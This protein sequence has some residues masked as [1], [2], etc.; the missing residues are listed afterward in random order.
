MFKYYDIRGVWGR[1]ID[2]WKAEKLGAAFRQLVEGEVAIGRDVRLSSDVLASHLAEGLGGEVVDIGITT[3]PM[4]YFFAWR[5]GIHTLQVTAS[6]NPP[7]YNGVKPIDEGG[8]DWPPEKIRELEKAYRDAYPEGNP[9]KLF[10]RE[11]VDDYFEIF[12]SWE[13]PRV[14]LGADLSSGAGYL[15]L[16]LLEVLFD[17]KAYNA[18]PDG[19]FPGHP[20]DPTHPL[21][22]KAFEEVEGDWG[23]MLDGDA[24][25]IAVKYR[26][27]IL[28]SDELVAFLAEKGAIGKKIAIEVTLPVKLEEY[29]KDLGMEVIRTPTGRVLIK[30]IARRENIDFF[31]EYSGH[32]GFKE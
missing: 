12:E 29:L 18:V 11:W 17:L 28:D 32:Y 13:V 15:Y 9:R 31:G 27:K 16:P 22:I 7:E 19:R 24:D 1:D 23:I 6:H 20:P 25:R 30:E 26:G 21:S 5:E 3:T 10:F 4:S 8:I 14:S 2:P